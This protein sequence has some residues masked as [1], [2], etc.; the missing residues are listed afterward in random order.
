MISQSFVRLIRSWSRQLWCLDKFLLN[1]ID[2]LWNRVWMRCLSEML[3]P[4]IS[5]SWI[6]QRQINE[7]PSCITKGSFGGVI[8][9]PCHVFLHGFVLCEMMKKKFSIIRLFSTFDWRWQLICSWTRSIYLSWSEMILVSNTGV[10]SRTKRV[11]WYII[12]QFNR[13]SS[14]SKTIVFN[15]FLFSF[16]FLAWFWA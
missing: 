9:S 15:W 1:I 16:D 2:G 12:W 8:I 7:F 10:K 6:I 13:I 5:R 14:W 11:L 3:W 4:M